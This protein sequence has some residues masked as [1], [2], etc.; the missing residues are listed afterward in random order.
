ML[1]RS[2]SVLMKLSPNKNNSA[3]KKTT[4]SVKAPLL[5]KASGKKNVAKTAADDIVISLQQPPDLKTAL[6]FI[7]RKL[8]PL[9]KAPIP[10]GLKPMLATIGEEAFNSNDWQFEI[11]WDG[12]RAI[13]YLN[14]G[15]VELSSRNNLPFNQ[16]FKEVVAALQTW[17]I[18]A[19]V[20][21]EVVVLNENGHADFE[22]LQG[23]HIAQKG[24][25]VYFVFDILWLDGY[26]L[27][28]LN[29]VE[30]RAI[31]KQLMPP[32]N[33][34]RFSDSIEDA[35]IDFFK[36]AQKNGLEGIIAK[37]K[38]APYITG[39]RTK[40]W[41]KIKS[42]ER[43]EAVICGYT[44][45][46]NTDRLFSSLVLGMPGKNG[47][48]YIGQV[49]TGF[50]GAVQNSLFKK[51][52]PLFVKDCPFQ[53]KPATGAPTMW[54]M[55]FGLRSKIYRTNKRRHYAPC[56]FSRFTGR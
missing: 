43:H 45:K 30:R 42:E 15:V 49:G 44:K 5:K 38:N 28:N 26:N 52:N 37:R 12:Y 56:F 47:L 6:Q 9:T 18:N 25:L 32:T 21:G 10:I 4:L 40:N 16:K 1:F 34:I 54:L 46:K 2:L 13:S 35:G 24:T 55:P 29:L 41:L 7:K 23:W 20:D 8:S 19:V 53:K 36:V 31:L 17:N 51:M 11:K 48:T 39:H 33:T 22:A 50:T 27:M 14:D 3:L